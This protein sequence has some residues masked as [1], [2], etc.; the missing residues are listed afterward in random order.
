[1][2]SLKKAVT[3]KGK[4]VYD[5]ETLLISRL[6]IVGQQRQIDIADVFHFEMSPGPT[7]LNRRVWVTA[8]LFCTCVCI[9]SKTIVSFRKR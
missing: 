8:F 1:M 3:I 4:A 5:I 9:M 7:A 2:E 6:L